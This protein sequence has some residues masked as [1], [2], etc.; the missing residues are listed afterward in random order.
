MNIGWTTLATAE[1][2][3]EFARN[4]VEERLA[5]C[6]QVDG[7][8]RSYY[9]WHGKME[10]DDEY[11]ITVK[12]LSENT[13]RLEAWISDKHP[14]DVPQ[15]LTVPVDRVLPAYREWAEEFSTQQK[16]LK[17]KKDVL[18]LSKMGRNFLRK[19]RFLEAEKIFLDALSLDGKNAY[20]LVG[21]ADTYRE[22]NKFEDAISYYERVLEFDSINVFALRGIGDAYRGILQHKRAIP[23]WMRYLE[24]NKDDI[25]VMVRLAESFNKKGNFEKA[26]GFY[27]QALG[28]NPKDKYALL[29][30]GSLYYKTEE[31]EKALEYFDNLLSIDDRYVAVLTMVGNIYR[32]RKDYNTASEYYQKANAIESWNS[33]ALYGLGDCCRGQE[34]LDQAV[35]WWSKILEKEPDNQD[36]LTRIG[37]AMLNMEKH[38]QSLEHYMKS[39]QVGF[40]L[41]ALLG[42]SRVHR[43]QENPA[44]AIKSCEQ[45]LEKVPGHHR[46]LEEL[47]AIY[48]EIGDLEKAAELQAQ[49]DATER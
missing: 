49:L 18:R 3:E 43:I 13:E 22:L 26:E 1:E 29:G 46:A 9:I 10:T 44:E 31:D 40:D 19:G 35:Y 41:Y 20:I 15:W 48:K 5:V 38:E 25:Y 8:I 14:Y 27:V 11:R 21:L 34:N 36:L 4:I 32:R 12:F 16:V 2:A 39:L 23:Y 37:D 47:V 7:P 24:R 6:T 28:V 17:P 33:F 42:L 30:L 45:I